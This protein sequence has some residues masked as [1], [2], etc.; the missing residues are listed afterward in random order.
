MP[1]DCNTGREPSHVCAL[2]CRASPPEMS[3]VTNTVID[4]T[5]SGTG[6]LRP[7]PRRSSGTVRSDM[8]SAEHLGGL[9][10][11]GGAVPRGHRQWPP[12]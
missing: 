8:I 6:D 3:T 11:G 5:P 10:V 7:T 1:C 9:G 2:P 4:H 12:W